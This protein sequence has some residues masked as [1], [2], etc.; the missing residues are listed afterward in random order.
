MMAPTRFLW[1]ARNY[2]CYPRRNAPRHPRLNAPRQRSSRAWCVST[3]IWVAAIDITSGAGIDP[4][5]PAFYLPGQE[6]G[7][8]NTRGFWVVDPC[9]ANGSSCE[10][11]DE[12]CAGFCRPGDKSALACGPKPPGCSHEFEKCATSTDCCGFAPSG[13]GYGCINGYCSESGEIVK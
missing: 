7:A 3:S 12:C 5:H 9:K 13:G 8:G 4:S 6:I 2:L 1:P 11:G 10:T